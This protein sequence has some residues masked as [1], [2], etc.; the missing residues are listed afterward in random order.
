MQVLAYRKNGCLVGICNLTDWKLQGIAIFANLVS[1]IK[2]GGPSRDIYI[3]ICDI[4]DVEDQADIEDLVLDI[5]GEKGGREAAKLVKLYLPD[6]WDLET[7]KP[8]KVVILDKEPEPDMPYLKNGALVCSVCGELNCPW[9]D[10]PP[11]DVGPP[12]DVGPPEAV[13]LNAPER[14]LLAR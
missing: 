10:R 13:P 1:P 4:T 9:M 11:E 12:P 7:A 3:V 8:Y 6:D 14:D 2:L 5:G